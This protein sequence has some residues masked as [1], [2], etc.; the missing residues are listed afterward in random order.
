MAIQGAVRFYDALVPG[1]FID[2]NGLVSDVGPADLHGKTEKLAFPDRMVEIDG[3]SLEGTGAPAAIWDAQVE[4]AVRAERGKVS[5]RVATRTGEVKALDLRL[6]PLSRAGWWQFAAASVLVGTLWAGAGLLALWMRRRSALARTTAKVGVLSGL[7][8]LTL[9]DLHAARHLVPVFFF[10][11]A[12]F[13]GSWLALGLRLPDDAPLL[14][15]VPW[16][17]RAIDLTGGAFGATLVGTYL[18]GGSTELL[19]K[20]A[21]WWL[22][23]CLLGFTATFVVRFVRSRGDRR[24]TMRAL[25]VAM[26]PPHVVGGLAA[27]LSAGGES[28]L[29]DYVYPLLGLAPLATLYAFVRHDLWQTRALLSRLLTRLALVAVFCAGAM[30]AG[31]AAGGMLSKPFHAALVA[32]SVAGVIA[33]LLVPLVL[34]WADRVIFPARASYKPTVAQ[35]SA[36]LTSISSPDEVARAIE[37]T[38][39]RWLPCE[40]V[41]L[42]RTGSQDSPLVREESGRLKRAKVE[43]TGELGMPLTFGGLHLGRLEVGRKR[44]GALFTSDDVDLLQT[45][46]DQGALALAHAL[47]YQELEERR[48]EEAAAWR[49]ERAAVLQ[50]V[51][52]EASHEVRYTINFLKSVFESGNNVL[53]TEAMEIGREE[54][55]R[56]ERLLKGLRG[57]APAGLVRTTVALRSLCKRVEILLRD[58]LADRRLVV[59]VDEEVVLRCDEDKVIQILVNLVGNALHATSG[60]GEVGIGFANASGGGE[61]TV[62]DTGPGFADKERL[63]ARWYTTKQTGSGLGLV[64][65]QRLVGRHDWRIRADRVDG[66]TL[67]VISV[68]AKD[69]RGESHPGQEG[70]S[71]ADVA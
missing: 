55:D 37:R 65:T 64:I 63:F 58:E 1:I 28:A 8:M 60:G 66:R 2:V 24:A 53:D 34:A 26:V 23:L 17:E 46:V 35:L 41:A 36:E 19:Q 10:A 56:L 29:G 22:A 62:W 71:D 21:S 4:K 69:L 9:F 39:A 57:L 61:I 70:A 42:V 32:A 48:R 52:L 13:P 43:D 49:G 50:T 44:G 67:F 38:V 30:A 3:V 45:I 5:V 14:A 11:Y 12:A 59:D 40:R 16:I 20:I 18:A 15:R 54:V 68:P 31:A 33:A 51:A 25:V 27:L 6:E 47:A 7:F